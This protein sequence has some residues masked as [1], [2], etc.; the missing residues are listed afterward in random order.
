MKKR[1]RK[2][3]HNI[4]SANIGLVLTLLFFL[5]LIIRGGQLSLSRSIDGIDLKQFSNNHTIK[6]ETIS[7]KRGNIYDSKGDVLA[8]NVYSY[9]LIA[10]L[11]PKRGE[12]YY[13]KDKE[14][15]AEQLATV[16]DMDYERILSLL[17]S[18]KDDGT[19]LYQTSFGTAGRG[20][21]E[22]TKEKIK[23]LNLPGIDFIETQK[24]YYPKGNYLSYTLGYAKQN[25]DGKINGEMGIEALFNEQLTGQDGFREYQKDLRGYRIANTPEVVKDAVDGNDIYL[26]IDSNVQFFIEQ[27]LDDVKNK[28]S[29]DELNIV[30][31][32]AKTGKIL[33]ISSTT[34]FDPNLR[35]VTSYLDPNISVSFEPGSTMKTFTYM[36]ALES[37][38][39]D[40]NKTF[41]SGIY[42]TSDGTE[43]G[44]SNRKGWGV[45]S[46]DRGFALSSN[47]GV[48][49]II[50]NYL[51]R[52][53]LMKYFKKLGFG[54]KTGIELSKETAGKVNFRY[55]TEV[56][57]AGFGQGIM[58][59]SIQ[60]I[61][62]LTSIA[63]DGMLLKPYIVE[64]IVDS[65]GKTVLQNGRTELG[66]VASKD[67]TNK[68][69]DLMET[70][71]T[72][73][74][75]VNYNMPG[76]NLIAKTGTAQISSTNGTGYLKGEYDFIRGFAGM[77]PKND[78]QIII[79]A[80][81]KRPR[82]NSPAPLTYVIKYVVENVSK[83][84]NIYDKETEN[85]VNTSYTLDNYYNLKIENVKNELEHN[86]V[87]V[88]II[89]DGDTV[90]NQYPKKGITITKGTKVFLLT[91][92]NNILIPNFSNWSKKD[93]HTYLNL[94]N[95]P[96]QET[97]NGYLVNQSIKDE[98]YKPDMQLVI[99]FVEKYQEE[100]KKEELPE[101]QK[102]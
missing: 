73:G 28:Y 88:A 36:A 63:N 68:I 54:S 46:Y 42:K 85:L 1:K 47:V 56:F 87:D 69:K 44:D 53:D 98:I 38:K 24:R 40:G 10:Y 26:T 57:N 5:I 102:E 84:Y 48:C 90:I 7:A 12:G 2:I 86:G 32:E 59:T 29:F 41:K 52:D 94:S 20:L 64:K 66:I 35:N 65:T 22:I 4:I 11:Q 99:E 14:Y 75:G 78:P 21:T 45:I 31:A 62:A 82:P 100:E 3:N 25:S 15:T 72:E 18:K 83:Y 97:G 9:E 89:G 49:N 79:Y 50:N 95:I 33:G 37:G 23:A 92:S 67:T 101:E 17:N 61:K 93:V 71:V 30:V 76:Y 91:N 34:S 70:V 58:V 13:V 96:Y 74:T 55:E 77:F 60:N 43:L 6:H 19:P 80:N 8:Q 16:I 81:L 27:A 39:Y 51:S